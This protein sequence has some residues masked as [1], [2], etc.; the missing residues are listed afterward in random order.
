VDKLWLDRLTRGLDE[1]KKNGLYRSLPGISVSDSRTVTLGGRVLL[2]FSGNDYLGLSQLPSIREAGEAAARTYGNG[3]TGSRLMSGN[4]RIFE[5]IENELASFLGKEKALIFNTGFHANIGLISGLADRETT[6]F[7]DKLNH[8]SIY[9]GVRLSGA[10]LVRYH[11]A[12]AADLEK[13]LKKTD[14]GR[15][16]LIVTDALFSMDGDAAPLEKICGLAKEHHCLLMVDEAHSFGVFGPGGRGLLA[17]RGLLDQT[18]LVMATFGK[19][20]GVFGA[21][22]AGPAV[23]IEH[24]VNACR[25][26]IFTTGLPPFVA[27]AVKEALRVVRESGRGKELLKKAGDFRT[28]LASS[29]LKTGSSVSQI[30]PLMTGTNELSLELKDHL[31]ENGIFS[32]AIRPPTVPPGT[33]RIRLS[34]NWTHTDEDLRKLAGASAEFFR[35][36]E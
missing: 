11:H 9:D 30:V 32:Q 4:S 31:L 5:E 10:E 34:L 12:D 1:R 8:A 7:C 27:G 20:F 26:F 22:A 29:G 33:A 16:K 35:D 19:S 24:L 2:N 21:F 28:L 18:D 13:K 25:P 36:R 17:D 3:S 23:L 6:V 15:Y 14:Q